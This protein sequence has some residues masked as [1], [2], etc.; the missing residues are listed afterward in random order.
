[1]DLVSLP[2]SVCAA[3]VEF[4]VKQS[5]TGRL[6]PWYMEQCRPGADGVEAEGRGSGAFLRQSVSLWWSY[7]CGQCVPV[8]EEWC[9]DRQCFC[10]C[11]CAYVCVWGVCVAEIIPTDNG[12]CVSG[13]FWQREGKYHG[14]KETHTPSR[15]DKHKRKGAL[16]LYVQRLGTCSNQ[17]RSHF[18]SSLR[19]VIN[20]NLHK[21][22][23]LVT[24]VFIEHS[25]DSCMFT[26]DC[27]I[28]WIFMH[29]LMYSWLSFV[30]IGSEWKCN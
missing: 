12:S 13:T 10:V 30:N 24:C 27:S 16:A 17:N 15:T 20:Q 11:A 14:R 25:L 6:G 4:D 2:D 21:P 19:R 22:L 18:L 5:K 8:S 7:K 23:R 3:C 28:T 26:D 29:V 9:T 1:M